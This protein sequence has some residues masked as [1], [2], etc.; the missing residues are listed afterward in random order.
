LLAAKP[1]GI[2]KSDGIFQA[3]FMPVTYSTNSFFLENLSDLRF[4]MIIQQL[5]IQSVLKISE[6]DFGVL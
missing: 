3:P 6:S 2:I 1:R 4:K 5:L